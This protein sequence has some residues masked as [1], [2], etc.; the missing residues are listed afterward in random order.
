MS[1]NTCKQIF[2]F[3]QISNSARMSNGPAKH[4]EL[5]MSEINFLVIAPAHVALDKC[6]NTQEKP[7]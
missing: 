2:I 4:I 1:K 5:A 6:Y 7:C 3:L